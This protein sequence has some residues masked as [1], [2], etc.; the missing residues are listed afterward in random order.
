MAAS[1]QDNQFK[2]SGIHAVRRRNKVISTKVSIDFH[3]KFDLLAEYPF[4]RGLSESFTPSALL[5]DIMEHLLREY[6]DGLMVYDNVQS[7]NTRNS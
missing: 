6:H 7:L 2:I 4:E 3:N 5:R 1:I